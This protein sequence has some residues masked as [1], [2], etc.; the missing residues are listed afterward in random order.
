MATA[1]IPMAIL[2]NV[3]VLKEELKLAIEQNKQLEF[4][5]TFNELTLS[6]D[7]Y[8]EWFATN[9]V[10]LINSRSRVLELKK[11]L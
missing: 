7:K 9:E 8:K 1:Q 10:A 3:E 6:S 11:K 4:L 5:N 2:S